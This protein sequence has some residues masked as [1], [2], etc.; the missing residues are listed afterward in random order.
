MTF[1]IQKSIEI[2]QRTPSILES[3]LTG[4]SDEWLRKRRSINSY[5]KTIKRISSIKIEK[6]KST[7]C[8]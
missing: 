5:R 6:H 7:D 3:I 8:F 4:L 2:L 1:D